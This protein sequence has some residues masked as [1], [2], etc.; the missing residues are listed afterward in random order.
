M[1]A[2]Q[3]EGSNDRVVQLENEVAE[4]RNREEDTRNKLNQIL[5]FVSQL[6]AKDTFESTLNPIIT[7][8]SNVPQHKNLSKT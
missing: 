3:E 4:M 8:R 1:S 2:M 5:N 7:D 6:K